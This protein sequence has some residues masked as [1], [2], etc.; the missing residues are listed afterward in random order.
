VERISRPAMQL[1]D[2][3]LMRHERLRTLTGARDGGI[4]SHDSDRASLR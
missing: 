4:A 2:V 1:P 3:R